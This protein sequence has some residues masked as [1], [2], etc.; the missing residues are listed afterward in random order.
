MALFSAFFSVFSSAVILAINSLYLEFGS[1]V[2]KS[3]VVLKSLLTSEF[4]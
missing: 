4:L 2:S 1:K 3:A